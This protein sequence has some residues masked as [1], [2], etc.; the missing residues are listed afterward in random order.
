MQSNLL[1]NNFRCDA[2]PDA[3]AKYVVA[4]LKKKDIEKESLKSFCVDQ[5]EVFLQARKFYEFFQFFKLLILET[6]EFVNRLFKKLEDKTYL[7]TKGS[8][9]KSAISEDFVETAETK[10]GE[11]IASSKK[12]RSESESDLKAERDTRRGAVKEVISRS[13]RKRISPPPVPISNEERKDRHGR[14]S[15]S[16]RERRRIEPPSP[17]RIRPE[18][19]TRR[20]SR[21]R[22]RSP[23]DRFERERR[24]VED[25]ETREEKRFRCRD[26]DERGFCMRGDKC[27]YD[28]GPDPVVVED[29]ALEKMVQMKKNLNM[30]VPAYSAL[31]PP[32]PGVDSIYTASSVS[33]LTEGILSKNVTKLICNTFYRLQS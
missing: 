4:L 3:L 17:V 5:L 13:T 11:N 2:D 9:N 29:T 30:T 1:I 6:N 15:R 18:R 27:P 24:K 19:Y 31:N 25:R 14:R 21:S 23:Y 7:E 12:L 26:F 10:S 16:P 22:S 32:P 8:P 20:K 28:H 33:S